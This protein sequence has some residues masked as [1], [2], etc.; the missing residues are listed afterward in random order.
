MAVANTLAY[1][2]TATITALK[3]FIVQTLGWKGQL[4]TNAIA[5]NA[6]ALFT[7]VKSFKVS[8]QELVF[9]DECLL[10]N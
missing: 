10:E 5:Y 1:Y 4:V 3:C 6:E 7:T 8:A 2:G 9:F